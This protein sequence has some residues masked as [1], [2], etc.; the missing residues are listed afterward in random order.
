MNKIIGHNLSKCRTQLETNTGK[1]V[2][3]KT[4][5]SLESVHE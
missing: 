2:L 4:G 1:I 3:P 5:E